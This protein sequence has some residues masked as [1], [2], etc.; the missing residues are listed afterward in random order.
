MDIINHLRTIIKNAG[1]K[2]Y[3]FLIG[4]INVPKLANFME[5]DM[6]V[7]VACPENSLIDSKDFFKPIATPFELEIALVKCVMTFRV[8]SDVGN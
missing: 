1:K 7:I 8:R 2:S 6:F 3:T 5:I 4:K